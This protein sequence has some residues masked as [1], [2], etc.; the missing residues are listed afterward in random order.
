MAIYLLHFSKKLAHAQHYLGFCVDNDP[1]DRLA[2]HIRGKKGAKIV[3]A[4]MAA[5]IGVELALIIPDGD[6]NFERKLK[7]RADV[8]R[9]CPVCA[10]NKR[11][12]PRF[13]PDVEPK[14]FTR[15]AMGRLHLFHAAPIFELDREAA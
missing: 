2:A 9:W 6:R 8:S 1:S 13:H 12:I 10:V 7:N 11:P 3:K 15:G 4:A 14:V 5:G